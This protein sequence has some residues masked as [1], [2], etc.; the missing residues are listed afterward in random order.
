MTGTL[1]LVLV[2]CLLVDIH[3][4]SLKDLF[5]VLVTDLV[6][7]LSWSLLCRGHYVSP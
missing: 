5:Q 7:S 2:F 1:I 4:S 6:Q 3:S